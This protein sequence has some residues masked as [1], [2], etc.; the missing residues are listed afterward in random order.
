MFVYRFLIYCTALLCA[1]TL[2][3]QTAR[4]YEFKE[5]KK[6]ACTPVKNQQKTGTCWSFS[7]T[8]FLESELI[9]RGKGQHD[10]SEMFVV[11]HIY[12]DKCENYVRRQ[13]SARLGEGG[14]AHDVLNAVRRH[15]VVPESVY[16]GRVDA[17]APYNHGALEAALIKV[18]NE[19]VEQAKKG[20]LDPKWLTRVDSVLD[21]EMG[22][23]A[24]GKF[25]VDNQPMSPERLRD[26]LGIRADEYVNI[27]SFTHH[28]FYSWFVLEVP[29]NYSNGWFYNVPLDDLMLTL[30][31]ALANGYTVEWDADVSNS[32]FS[33]QQG[34]A[35]VPAVDWKNKNEAQ[36]AATFKSWETERPVT[37]EY[38]QDLFDR[39]VTMDDHLMHIVGRTVEHHGTPFYVVKNSWGD[40][41]ETGGFVH[42]SDAYMRLNTISFTVHVDA[43]PKQLR[44]R[45]GLPTS[46][47]GVP[48]TPTP[49]DKKA[50]QMAPS[51]GKGSSGG[52][53]TGSSGSMGKMPKPKA[54]KKG[55]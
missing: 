36:R 8:S 32:N 26:Y 4:P 42:V 7:T 51:V 31:N 43:L 35:I 1:T 50:M 10:L 2:P 49:A 38:R 25:R 3:A 41:T 23:L 15:G 12:R 17:N 45:L 5:P 46:T 18:C 16:P 47:A 9:R 20:Q 11:R 40:Q 28:P 53:G 39:Q 37:Q 13:G 30:D 22:P 48:A 34:L 52:S 14:L 27:T 29:D 44:E 19:A 21:A 24:G 54:G 33:H 6:L 55:N